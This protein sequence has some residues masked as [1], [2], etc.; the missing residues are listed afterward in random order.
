MKLKTKKTKALEID[1][2]LEYEEL[3]ALEQFWAERYEE[4]YLGSEE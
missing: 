4:E 1:E 3:E 2:F